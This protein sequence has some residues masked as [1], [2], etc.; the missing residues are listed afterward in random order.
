M[1]VY[2]IVNGQTR[3]GY[4]SAIAVILFLISLT[5][6]LVYQRLAMRRDLAGAVTG[7]VR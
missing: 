7:G 5:V 6:A 4:G 2:M 3:P 1:A